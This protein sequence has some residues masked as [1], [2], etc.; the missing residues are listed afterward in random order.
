MLIE[1]VETYLNTFAPWTQSGVTYTVRRYFTPDEPDEVITLIEFPAGAGIWAMGPSLRAPVRERRGL[2][3][4]VR[5]PRKD[6]ANAAAMAEQVHLK[7]AALHATLSGRRYLITEMHPMVMKEEDR[8]NRWRYEG[9][10]LVQKE[11]G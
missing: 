6:A 9:N 10:Y 8:N 7:L 4:V 2:M 1:D 5:G 11:R 3:V